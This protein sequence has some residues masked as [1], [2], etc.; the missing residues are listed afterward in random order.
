M[1]REHNKQEMNMKKL[2]CM[3]MVLLAIMATAQEIRLLP[4]MSPD[5]GSYEDQVKVS[6]EFPEGCAGGLYWMDGAEIAAQPYTSSLVI[7]YTCNLSVAGVNADGR[8][9]TD[10]VTQ[11]YEINKVTPPWTTPEP[12]EGIRVESF[13]VTKIRWNNVMTSSLDLSAFKEGGSRAG[14][15]AV[16]LTNAAGKMVAYNDYNGLWQEGLNGYKAYIYK[17]YNQTIE[18]KYTLHIAADVFILDGK[19]Y[20]KELAYEYEVG[21]KITK[22]VFAPAGGEYEDSV[23]VT[24]TY[25]DENIAFYRFYSVNGKKTRPYSESFWIKENSNIMAWGVD[26][27]YTKVTDT[28]YVSYTILKGEEKTVLDA[29]KMSRA[30]NTITISGPAGATIKYW[31]NDHMQTGKLYTVPFEVTENG[32]VS[33][34]AYTDKAISKTVDMEI[35]HFAP[36]DRG[37]KGDLYLFT[38]SNTQDL[39]VN[40]M[41]ANGRYAVGYVGE[42]SS[43]KGFL[44]DLE[45]DRLEYVKSVYVNQLLDVSNDGTAYGWTLQTQ[46]VTQDVTDEDMLLGTYKNGEWTE[47]PANLGVQGIAADSRLY[48]A[49]ST[50]PTMYDIEKGEFAIYTGTGEILCVGAESGYAAGYVTESGSTYPAVWTAEDKVVKAEWSEVRGERVTAISANGEWALIGT[51]WRWHVSAN[52]IEHMLSVSHR[53]SSKTYPE[54]MRAIANDGTVY[55]TYVENIEIPDKG[56]ALIYTTDGRWRS[57]ETYLK[58]ERGV[59][60]VGY[61]LTSVRAISADA[62]QLLL[63]AFATN[64]ALGEIFTRGVALRLDVQVKHLYPNSLLATQ[65][66]GSGMVKVTW[67][68]PLLGAEDVTAYTLLRDGKK[69][70]EGTDLVYIDKDTETGKTYTYTVTASYKDGVTSTESYAAK[71]TIVSTHHLPVTNLSARQVGL[72]SLWINWSAPVVSIPKLQYFR[73]DKESMAFGTSNHSSEWGIRIPTEDLEAYKGEKIRTLQFLPVGRQDGYTLNLYR[74]IKGTDDYEDKPFYSQSISP[75]ALH[76]GSVNTIVLEEA[77]AIPEGVDLYVALYI[78]GDGLNMLGVQ[79]DGFRSGYTDLCRVE[80]VHKKMVSISAASTSGYQIV[81]PLGIGICSEEQLGKSLIK[82]Y[83]VRDQGKVVATTNEL[84]LKIDKAEMG[85]HVLDVNV[86]YHDGEYSGTNETVEIEMVENIEAYHGVEARVQVTEHSAEVSWQQPRNDDRTL[87][88]WGDMIPSVGFPA[89]PNYEMFTAVSIYPMDMTAPYGEDYE[90]TGV[91]F[92]PTDKATFAISLEDGFDG[93]LAHFERKASEVQLGTLNYI[94]LKNPISLNPSYNFT[95]AIDVMDAMPG[96]SPLAFDSSNQWKD[97]FSNVLYL[98]G[99]YMTLLDVMEVGVRPSWLMGLVIRLKDS[100]AIPVQGYNLYV[101]GE[102]QNTELLTTTTMMV[103]DLEDGMH[104]AEVDVVYSETI[105]GKGI[106]TVFLVGQ[107]QAI[108]QVEAELWGMGGCYDLLGRPADEHGEV[109]GVYIVNGKK[110]IK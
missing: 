99:E 8:I 87:L 29:P 91:Y 63:Y 48:G 72:H 19:R 62:D 71:V 70:Y 42:G 60:V 33:A 6:C 106:P 101:D 36:K 30:G 17:G 93:T 57:L 84:K 47:C 10:V 20:D 55:G 104:V 49:R 11:H 96:T 50:H 21:A 69:I 22:P 76:Y 58:E 25:P 78:D 53:F 74:G 14:E 12:A 89:Q 107:K 40:K 2:I 81:V 56:M 54:S 85:K 18:G 86:L 1:D 105:Q 13:Y 98:D 3:A 97:A 73:E 44:W 79:F 7:D 94:S 68:A 43:S 5:G 37:D 82:Q 15:P 108:E 83:E 34:V 39:H 67:G 90:I 4:V 26:E 103:N 51:H 38:P 77:Q 45:A 9:I 27:T 52:T 100:E 28:A 35:S 23:L 65:M 61:A 102:Q 16:W 75:D 92:Y 88:H 46:D 41:S 110:V 66:P 95:L 24:I 59:T 80:G 109:H 32:R 64:P 31:L